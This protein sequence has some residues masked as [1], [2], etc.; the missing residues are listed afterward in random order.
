VSD[1]GIADQCTRWVY[2][3]AD[4]AA[5]SS[6]CIGDPHAVSDTWTIDPFTVETP[7]LVALSDW[8]VSSRLVTGISDL[9]LRVLDLE[10]VRNGY[11]HADKVLEE[12][13]APGVE[14]AQKR[15]LEPSGESI[16]PD[17]TG[18]RSTLCAA[19]PI[20][21]WIESG[22]AH[23]RHLA[24][25]G[26]EP[27]PANSRPRE[28]ILNWLDLFCSTQGVLVAGLAIYLLCRLNRDSV[29]RVNADAAGSDRVGIGS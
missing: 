15:V 14:S 9:R 13:L 17:E 28:V 12:I 2:P 18:E 21:I 23:G 4:I 22:S 8:L 10:G 11:E 5:G 27:I 3:F 20:T 1:S 19:Q 26:I 16:K 29:E 24:L 7:A 6:R 25:A